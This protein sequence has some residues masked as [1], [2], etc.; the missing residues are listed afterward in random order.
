MFIWCNNKR[1]WWKANAVFSTCCNYFKVGIE[2]VNGPNFLH[3]NWL[4][5]W[6]FKLDTCFDRNFQMIFH[7]INQIAEYVFVRVVTAFYSWNMDFV[8]YSAG[9]RNLLIIK[10]TNRVDLLTWLTVWAMA[11]LA[12]KL[13][14]NGSWV[15]VLSVLCFGAAIVDSKQH[16]NLYQNTC[17]SSNNFCM[18]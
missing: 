12:Q 15:V 2:L 3:G 4:A 17:C 6:L 8:T 13:V 1:V 14:W 5:H 11:G 9:N 18:S 16:L 7:K 10:S